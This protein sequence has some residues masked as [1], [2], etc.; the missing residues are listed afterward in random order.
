[1]K[2]LTLIA[3]LFFLPGTT[4]AQTSHNQTGCFGHGCRPS[5][6]VPYASPPQVI[7]QPY[8]VYRPMQYRGTSVSQT[9]KPTL[10]GIGFRLKGTQVQHY[11]AP[12]PPQQPQPYQQQP[13]TS[14][15]YYR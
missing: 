14:Q 9:W 11:Y 10:F 1:M 3:A 7:Y 6:T 13:P 5:Y 15:R 4:E 12:M 2:Y 8:T